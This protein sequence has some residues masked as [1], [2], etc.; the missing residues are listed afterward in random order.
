M[1]PIKSEAARGIEKRKKCAAR[2]LAI[3]KAFDLPAETVH[4][5]STQQL[6]MMFPDDVIAKLTDIAE[7][8]VATQT[9]TVEVLHPEDATEDIK[10]VFRQMHLRELDAVYDVRRVKGRTG[11]KSDFFIDDHHAHDTFGPSEYDEAIHAKF[12]IRVGLGT[13]G[14]AGFTAYGSLKF[15]G[16][17]G[18]ER[19]PAWT[20]KKLDGDIE[21]PEVVRYKHVRATAT[22]PF[23]KAGNST[24]AGLLEVFTALLNAV[25]VPPP[26]A[27]AF[28]I[29]W[30]HQ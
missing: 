21:H 27:E 20:E 15:D 19:K 5:L 22:E 9:H 18:I 1:A 12:D 6:A 17:V 25:G 13:F 29:T 8:A 28:I 23:M 3:C 10:H 24:M 30:V 2:S 26:A 11:E 16:V 4:M 14:N 7:R